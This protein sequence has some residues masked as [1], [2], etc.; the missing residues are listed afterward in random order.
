[1]VSHSPI[2]SIATEV[3][4]FYP[5]INGSILVSL[6]VDKSQIANLKYTKEGSKPAQTQSYDF[7]TQ[8]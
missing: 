1:M 6:M 8:G 2:V 7:K 5:R 3:T 4:N